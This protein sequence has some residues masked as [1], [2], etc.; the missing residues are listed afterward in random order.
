MQKTQLQLC[1]SLV[2]ADGCWL[3]H[4]L[5]NTSCPGCVVATASGVP[6]V[7][8]PISRLGVGLLL[9]MVGRGMQGIGEGGIKLLLALLLGTERSYSFHVPCLW[10]TGCRSCLSPDAQPQC[11]Y[12]DT[13]VDTVFCY[14][15]LCC[16][17]L[18]PPSCRSCFSQARPGLDKRRKNMFKRP[19]R[20]C[21][22]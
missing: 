11:S 8:S 20:S 18:I 16:Q 21:L 17:S 3:R 9:A 2:A 10:T 1:S 5:Q 7:E 4:S 14:S 13:C 6:V 19:A 15:N 22:A 12:S